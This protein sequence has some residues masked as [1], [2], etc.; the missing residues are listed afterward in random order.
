M[1]FLYEYFSILV[2]TSKI[3]YSVNRKVPEKTGFGMN[4]QQWSQF[5]FR[6]VKLMSKSKINTSKLSEIYKRFGGAPLSFDE[7]K[8]ALLQLMRELG[9]EHDFV[10]SFA[11][12]TLKLAHKTYDELSVMYGLDRS[13]VAQMKMLARRQQ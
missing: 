13:I 5:Y 1:Q 2:T 6:I 3:Q 12:E 10:H 7:F 4:L 9:S 8:S 11:I